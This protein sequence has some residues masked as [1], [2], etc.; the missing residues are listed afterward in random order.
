MAITRLAIFASGRGTNFAAL[1]HAIIERQLNAEFVR[2]IVDHD[3]IGAIELAIEFGVPY[4]V[5][6]YKA[7][8]NRGLAE[9]AIVAQLQA[10]TVDGIILA[11]YMRLL[12][13]VLL[14][15]FKDRIVNIHPALL[16]SFPGTH[17]IDDAFNYGVKITGV[18]VHYV[19]AGMDTG[20]IIAQAPVAIEVD[21][22]LETL[23]ARIHA[24]EHE[25][26]P[27]TL[28]TLLNEGVFN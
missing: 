24:T 4:T 2:L 7:Y 10:D 19:D 28:E 15:P 26:Y 23:E 21:D 6:N 20:K 16:P 5:I 14:D 25:L 3:N 17:G 13:P 1:Q 11:G 9:A 8:D 27:N 12:T 22:T 18:T